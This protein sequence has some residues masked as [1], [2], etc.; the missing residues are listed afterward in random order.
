ML[1]ASPDGGTPLCKQIREVEKD[2]RSNLNKIKAA[3][4]KVAVTIFTDGSATDGDIRDALKGLSSLPVWVVIKM[5]TDEASIVDYWNSVESDI[6]LALD[7]L[8][9]FENEAKELHKFN[10]WLTYGKPLHRLREAGT[11]LKFLDM[12]DERTLALDQMLQTVS[13][14][15]GISQEEFPDVYSNWTGFTEFVSKIQRTSG[16]KTWCSVTKREKYWIDV[17]KLHAMYA[18]GTK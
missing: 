3:K 12:M 14:I 16:K 1:K 6:E 10:S 8:E 15:S 11:T 17:D 9:D 4:Q 5:C 18:N 2:I 7:I 13:T